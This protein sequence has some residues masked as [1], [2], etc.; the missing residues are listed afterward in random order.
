MWEFSLEINEIFTYLQL[1]L[2]SV[3]I[4]NIFIDSVWKSK[5]KTSQKKY[6]KYR[7]TFFYVSLV[8]LKS[9]NLIIYHISP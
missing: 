8:T 6:I 3:S 2:V 1:N 4:S 7:S 9:F 5:Y